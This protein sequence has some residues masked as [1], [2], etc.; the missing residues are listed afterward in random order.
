MLEE[1]RTKRELIQLGCQGRLHTEGRI[2]AG[3]RRMCW[4]L[5]EEKKRGQ[6][7]FDL[8][9]GRTK[10]KSGQLL[11]KLFPLKLLY[12]LFLQIQRSILNCLQHT[13]SLLSIFQS[14][15]ACISC[16]SPNWILNF[17]VSIDDTSILL[18]SKLRDLGRVFDWSSLLFSSTLQRSINS[19]AW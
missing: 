5:M 17:S 16:F 4:T 18:V 12:Y 10:G 3:Y 11:K 8:G 15:P 7:I 2:W 13:S 9:K 1:F 6:D 14:Q 19:I